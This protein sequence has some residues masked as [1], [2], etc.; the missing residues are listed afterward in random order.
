MLPGKLLTSIKYPDFLDP[1]LLMDAC[2]A[3]DIVAPTNFHFD[4]CKKAIRKGKQVFVEKPLANSMQ[5][6]GRTG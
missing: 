1:E 3:V 6:A 5:E 4:L 2:D